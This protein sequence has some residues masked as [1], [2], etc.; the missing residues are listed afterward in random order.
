M[1][2]IWGG[3]VY[4]LS[5]NK[6]KDVCEDVYHEH[7]ENQLQLLGWYKYLREIHHK[8]TFLQGMVGFSPI[9]L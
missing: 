8:R 1:K 9:L 5:E 4:N 2:K 3:F 6:Q 7:V